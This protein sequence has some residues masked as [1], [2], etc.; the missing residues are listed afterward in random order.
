MKVDLPYKHSTDQILQ[1][2]QTAA[3]SLASSTE[4][5]TVGETSGEYK[6]VPGS[7]KIVAAKTG[8]RIV[9]RL[10]RRFFPKKL[11]INLAPLGK[12][13]PYHHSSVNI[14]LKVCFG[15][16]KDQ[17]PGGWIKGVFEKFLNCFYNELKHYGEA[18]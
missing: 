15:E 16:Y 9:R 7:V 1:A 14:D 8:M 18:A 4:D 17:F 6:Y 2:F 12:D 3:E 10:K 5:W 13:Y 11:V